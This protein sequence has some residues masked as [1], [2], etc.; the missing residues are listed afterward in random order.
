V[1]LEVG[2]EPNLGGPLGSEGVR[3]EKRG[4]DGLA[5]KGGWAGGWAA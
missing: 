2:D 4:S 1:W 5:R 3:G